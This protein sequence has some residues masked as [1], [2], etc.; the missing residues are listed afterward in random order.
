M[1][2]LAAAAACWVVAHL[3]LAQLLRRAGL[4]GPGAGT[5]RLALAW[6]A[7]CALLLAA[8]CAPGGWGGWGGWA[9]LTG[10]APKLVA[11]AAVA[12]GSVFLLP[13]RGVPVRPLLIAALLVADAAACSFVATGG[14]LGPLGPGARLL[15][16]AAPL[17]WAAGT[18]A[19]SLRTLAQD[20]PRFGSLPLSYALARRLL[21][22]RGVDV[23]STT[24]RISVLGVSLGVWLVLVS[25]GVL[26]GFER[27]LT[28]K[29]VGSGAE[30]SLGAPGGSQLTWNDDV[31][32]MLSPAR[33][34]GLRAAVPVVEA[35]L[36]VASGSNYAAAQLLGVEP[37]KAA[38]VLGVVNQLSA[39][40]RRALV[41]PCAPHCPVVLGS[42]L[43]RSL[44]VQPGETVRLIS[45]VGEVLTPLGPVPRSIGARVV[46]TVSSRM[47]E[48]DS[49]LVVASL[50]LA[51]RLMGWADDAI[52]GVQL[53]ATQPERV[54][55]LASAARAA[56]AQALGVP[57]DAVGVQTWKQRNQTLFAALELERVVA[58]V[59][60]AF[61]IL[62]ASFSIVNT[63]S[64][65]IFERRQEIAMLKAMG[66]TDATVLQVFLLQGVLIG[67]IG[68]V[69]GAVLGVATLVLLHRVGFGIPYEVYYIDALPVDIAPKDVMG[70]IAAAWLTVWNFA[71][72][73]S[74]Q[75]AALRP[76]EG[77]RDA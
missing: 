29:I 17:C 54:D 41:G 71:V 68:T 52:S 23:V 24:T 48:T 37:Q 32:R 26:S 3:A 27:D 39:A 64:M 59:V 74:S 20:R 14:I 1:I 72:V 4:L 76:A 45:P 16:F 15:A 30:V 46:G 60:L 8:E 18:F 36:A 6:G 28:D 75:A 77:L 38:Q 44:G 70:V 53:A 57:A 10:S 22:S 58:A 40:Q 12:A 11:L 31:A 61:I 55:A 13:G 49:R 62:V 69:V 56:L 63:L 5:R 50:P 51:R 66:A 9:Q 33:V 43:A 25:M 2:C 7:G 67:G 35:E 34:G 19:A 65:S 42:E 73:P 21:L 47:Y